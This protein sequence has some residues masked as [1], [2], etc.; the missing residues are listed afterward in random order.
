MS[1]KPQSLPTSASLILRIQHGDQTAW[2]RVEALYRPLLRYWCDRQ[3]VANND[4]DDIIQDVFVA[5]NRYIA[6]FTAHGDKVCFR[7]WLKTITRRKIVDF[8]RRNIKDNPVLLTESAWE[9]R[10]PIVEAEE[11]LSDAE[12][13]I[14]RETEKQIL[15]RQIFEQIKSEVNA[16]TW[17][18]FLLTTL[19][20]E[21]SV[22]VAAKLGMTPA[23]V[24]K[25]KSNVTKRIK[26]EF[27]NLI[28]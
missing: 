5:V 14:E 24:R 16:N 18:A 1:S 25:A 9:R 4:A 23:N 2:T 22:S 19:G 26:N 12:M 8:Y 7:P 21:D 28:Q 10:Q 6:D 15:Y 3:N 13:E 27:G 20:G 11:S 17:E